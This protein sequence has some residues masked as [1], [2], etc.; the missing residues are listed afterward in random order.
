MR[1]TALILAATFLAA[2]AVTGCRSSRLAQSLD[3][4]PN[5]GPCPVVGSVYD[6]ARY[7]KFADGSGE[8]YS[9][10]AYTGEITDVRIYC[11]YTDDI[12]LAAEIEIDFAYGKGPKAGADSHIYPYFVAV[13]R[14]NGKVL[15][16]ETFASEAEFRGKT[17]TGK[18]ELVN[19]ISIPRA[20]GSISGVN[21]EVV[22][23]FD[24]TPEQLEFNRAGKRFR[25][26]AGAK[27]AE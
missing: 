11:R 9:D 19:R 4:T 12:P 10:I 1:R 13:T 21:F 18:S 5:A 24:L 25:L 17:L 14:R 6:A 8:L 2:T 16:K 20:D 22:V 23:G 15:A 26:D 3:N 27:L 7:V